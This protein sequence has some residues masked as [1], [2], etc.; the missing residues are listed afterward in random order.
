MVLQSLIVG[1][2][3]SCAVCIVLFISR[4]CPLLTRNDLIFPLFPLVP[5]FPC[6][7]RFTEN[8]PSRHT[9]R[10][11]KPSCQTSTAPRNVNGVGAGAGTVGEKGGVGSSGGAGGGVHTAAGG[12]DRARGT[13]RRFEIDGIKYIMPTFIYAQQTRF[14]V[15]SDE[16]SICKLMFVV[17]RV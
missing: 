16:A 3:K 14:K 7:E 6:Q 8:L 15:T 2:P 11:Y 12:G 5:S 17:V 4:P 1:S 9:R 13:T 10:V